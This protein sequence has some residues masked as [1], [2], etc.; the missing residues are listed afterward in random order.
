MDGLVLPFSM[1]L[2]VRSETPDISERSFW[3]N[4]RDSRRICNFLKI[5]FIICNILLVFDL[6][7]EKTMNTS[8]NVQYVA[9]FVCVF[10]RNSRDN[11]H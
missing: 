3:L 1:A 6:K 8:M 7:Y 10:F 4:P 9:Q 2:M 5:S 11:F